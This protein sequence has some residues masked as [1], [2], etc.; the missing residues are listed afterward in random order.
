MLKNDLST[1]NEKL[2]AAV[3]VPFFKSFPKYK[4]Y[5]QNLFFNYKDNI[6][7]YMVLNIVV[8]ETLVFSTKKR[9]P[10]Y[11]CLEIFRPEE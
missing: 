4:A 10:Y 1:I 3:Y 5:L 11:V 9:A 8:E 6:R 2:P 7:N